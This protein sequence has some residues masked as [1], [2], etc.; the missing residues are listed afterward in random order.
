MNKQRI[1]FT[2]ILVFVVMAVTI[3]A[4]GCRGSAE[5]TTETGVVGAPDIEVVR[6]EAYQAFKAEATSTPEPVDI[7]AVRHQAYQAFKANAEDDVE[8][9][10]IEVV[11]HRA[12]QAFKAEAKATETV[13]IEVVRHRAYQAFRVEAAA[14]AEATPAP[15][16][17]DIE[18]LR[19]RYYTYLKTVKDEVLVRSDTAIDKP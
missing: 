19:H 9:T 1:G 7:E 2:G 11:R 14:S 13:D 5:A 18:I 3:L 15:E 17:V 10:D 4:L 16:T 6:H 8:T 12:Y